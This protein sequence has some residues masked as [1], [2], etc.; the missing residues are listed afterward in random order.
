MFRMKTMYAHIVACVVLSKV[1][2]LSTGGARQCTCVA[3]II[4]ANVKGNVSKEDA[5]T[6]FV[7]FSHLL[8]SS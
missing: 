7:S 3:A 1:A 6:I 2:G 5:R 8:G 4:V